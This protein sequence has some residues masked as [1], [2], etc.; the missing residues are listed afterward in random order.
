M[1][2]KVYLALKRIFCLGGEYVERKSGEEKTHLN[3]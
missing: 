2:Q 3:H 1:F